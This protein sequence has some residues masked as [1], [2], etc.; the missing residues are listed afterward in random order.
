MTREEV[1]LIEKEISKRNPIL[2]KT[3]FAEEETVEIAEEQKE[4]R[5]V[6]EMSDAVISDDMTQISR[7]FLKA[8]PHEQEDLIIDLINSLKTKIHG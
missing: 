3:Q 5:N 7:V 2:L 1:F 4:E 8:Y 6:E